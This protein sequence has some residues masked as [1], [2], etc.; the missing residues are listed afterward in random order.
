[1]ELAFLLRK[2]QEKA[3][4]EICEGGEGVNQVDI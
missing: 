4:E 3:Q 2:Q 1:M